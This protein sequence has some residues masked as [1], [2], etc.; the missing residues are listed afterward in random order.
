MEMMTLRTPVLAL[1]IGE[2][3]SGGA[4]AL[5]VADQVW[6]MEKRGVFRDFSRGLRQYPMERFL[7][8]GGRAECLKLTSHDLYKMNVIEKI[9]REPKTAD[10]GRLYESLGNLI[11]ET[12][13][14]AKKLPVEQLL[15]RRYQR[16]ENL[17]REI[18]PALFV[19]IF[20]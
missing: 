5:A 18:N 16:F 13:Q 6:M 19:G 9:I 12:F 10:S 17:G 15:E 7:K 2:G 3:G 8:G 11:Y 4:L 20:Q 1:L 14:E